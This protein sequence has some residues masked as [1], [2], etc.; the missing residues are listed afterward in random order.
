[1]D[2]WRDSNL[3]IIREDTF[4]SIINLRYY[5]LNLY[6]KLNAYLFVFCLNYDI[7]YVEILFNIQIC[8]V[9][10][11]ISLYSHIKTLYMLTFK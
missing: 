1:M 10:T 6:V 5:A 4:N 3:S 8:D 7:L 9:K 2:N 11:L